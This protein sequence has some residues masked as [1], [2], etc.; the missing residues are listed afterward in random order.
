M[1]EPR[2]PA[3]SGHR[4]GY[5]PP[6]RALGY[7]P[8]CAGDESQ[9]KR[10]RRPRR[11]RS[12]FRHEL[13]KVAAQR[14]DISRCCWPARLSGTGDLRGSRCPPGD[15]ARAAFHGAAVAAGIPVPTRDPLRVPAQGR[16]APA[17]GRTSPSSFKLS[18]RLAALL[19]GPR[20]LSRT[21][22]V[23]H[24]HGRQWR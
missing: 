15:Q 11:I 18:L 22:T 23:W 24:D 19:R 10:C 9:G 3:Y 17:N 7:N 6:L 21:A 13:I 16:I 5:L 4:F 1:L 20:H 12:H 8:G 14:V 2:G